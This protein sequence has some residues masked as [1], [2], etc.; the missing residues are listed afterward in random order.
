MMFD[1]Y[2]EQFYF[3]EKFC[4][5]IHFTAADDVLRHEILGE[6]VKAKVPSLEHFMSEDN[7]DQLYKIPSLTALSSAMRL[8][9]RCS[10]LVHPKLSAKMTFSLIL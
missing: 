8:L 9:Q 7:A 6:Y 1:M 4:C 5:C 2:F 10:S 3:T